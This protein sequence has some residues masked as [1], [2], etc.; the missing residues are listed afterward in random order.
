MSKISS[1]VAYGAGSSIPAIQYH[2][3][4]SSNL[5]RDRNGW[6]WWRT[7]QYNSFADN[8]GDLVFRLG[9]IVAMV[10]VLDDGRISVTDP[11]YVCIDGKCVLYN[12]SVWEDFVNNCPL[13]VF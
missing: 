6:G 8:I 9:G 7:V 10:F 3:I 12:E 1:I 2:G 11:N 4:G 13:L 5:F